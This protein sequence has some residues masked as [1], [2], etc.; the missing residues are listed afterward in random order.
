MIIIETKIPNGDLYY[1]GALN[2]ELI[3]DEYTGAAGF[4]AGEPED[5]CL[6]RD[7]NDAFNIKDMLAAAYNA[8]KRGETITI[9]EVEEE[10]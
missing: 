1:E 9:T 8:G 3:T 2:I 5:N 6:G 7:L 10:D 4:G